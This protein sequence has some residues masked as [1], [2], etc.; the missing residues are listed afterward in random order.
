MSN[1]FKGYLYTQGDIFDA[2]E[3]AAKRYR[4]GYDKS[5]TLLSMTG[6]QSALYE[7]QRVRTGQPDR[8]A[9]DAKGM[10]MKH[11]GPV[12]LAE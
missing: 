8:A 2:I 7:I 3:Y 5:D 6:L 12:K 11:G 9:S 10:S 4:E 1:G